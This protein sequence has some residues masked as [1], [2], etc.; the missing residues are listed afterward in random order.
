MAVTSSLWSLVKLLS[1]WIPLYFFIPLYFIFS[2]SINWKSD[3]PSHLNIE[4]SWL[5]VQT[6]TSVYGRLCSLAVP[7]CFGDCGNVSLSTHTHAHARN[8]AVGSDYAIKAHIYVHLWK[9]SVKTSWVV[10]Y[11]FFVLFYTNHILA[12]LNNYSQCA[13][14]LVIIVIGW[15]D[16]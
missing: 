2:K 9:S 4:I 7:S 5:A 12:L 8:R 1:M 14:R 16:A 15:D 11:F 6:E 13:L 10:Q 3:L